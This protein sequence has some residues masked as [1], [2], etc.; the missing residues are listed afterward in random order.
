[1]EGKEREGRLSCYFLIMNRAS[2]NLARD[3]GY[4]ESGRRGGRD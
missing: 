2:G 3:G 4:L 1:M